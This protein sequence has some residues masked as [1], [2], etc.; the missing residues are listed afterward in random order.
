MG[1]AEVVV[2]GGIAAGRRIARRFAGARVVGRRLCIA[3]FEGGE[4]LL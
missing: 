3:M 4:R 1:V 2:A